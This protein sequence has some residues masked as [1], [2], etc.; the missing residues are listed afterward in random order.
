MKS[1]GDFLISKATYDANNQL[2]YALV[3]SSGDR[4]F[5]RGQVIDKAALIS[6]I[7]NRV[8]FLTANIGAGRWNVSDRVRAFTIGGNVYLRVDDNRVE[9][10]HLGYHCSEVGMYSVVVHR[11]W[12]CLF[13]D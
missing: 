5:E 8:S 6:D 7:N 2:L 9:Y 3:H 4:N 11:K 1:K 12:Y 13:P 10:D